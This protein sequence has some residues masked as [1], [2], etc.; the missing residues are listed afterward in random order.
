MEGGIEIKGTGGKMRG[1]ERETDR[2][3]T[4]DQDDK[5]DQRERERRE[6]G[7]TDTTRPT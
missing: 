3:Y 6:G 5:E 1:Q 4:T 7:L 2:Q